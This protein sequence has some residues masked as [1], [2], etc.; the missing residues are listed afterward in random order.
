MEV[1]L[2]EKVVNLGNLGDQVSVKP[3]YGR[4]YLI[5]GGKAVMAT[6]DNVAA[7]EARRA[8]LEAKAAEVLAVAQGRAAKL[9]AMEEG[10]TIGAN[11]GD[12]G[13]LFGSVTPADIADAINAAGGDV[14][15]AE[16]KMPEG[17]I[18]AIG[19]Y[20]IDV[21]LHTDVTQAVTVNVVAE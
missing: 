1:I 4:N 14:D 11:A 5:P 3:G 17:P 13:K 7:F 8:D 2:L 15:K 9:A 19:E 12:E 6:A 10:V 16:V 21:Q 20:S 18:R